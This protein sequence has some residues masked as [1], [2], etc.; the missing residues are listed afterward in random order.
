MQTDECWNAGLTRCCHTSLR[1]PACSV[2]YTLLPLLIICSNGRRVGGYEWQRSLRGT[3]VTTVLKQAENC[4]P[5]KNYVSGAKRIVMESS[6]P[7]KLSLP[8]SVYSK[9]K[10]STRWASPHL[11]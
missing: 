4:M 5:S 6:A 3:R 1:R 7:S 8:T 11:A 9:Q 10:Q 2:L